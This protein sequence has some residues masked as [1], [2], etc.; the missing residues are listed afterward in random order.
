MN[1][2]DAVG[3]DEVK[4]EAGIFSSVSFFLLAVMHKP[5][6]VDDK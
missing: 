5:L 2:G 3:T 6:E 1:N 4:E